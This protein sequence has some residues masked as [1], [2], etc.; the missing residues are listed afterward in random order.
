[1]TKKSFLTVLMLCTFFLCA[2]TKTE[3]KTQAKNL[4]FP[5]LTWDMTPEDVLKALQTEKE[6]T[7]IYDKNDLTTSFVIT[8]INVFGQQTERVLF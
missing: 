5:A 8:G 7:V 4:E 2:C 3:K 1:M 6:N